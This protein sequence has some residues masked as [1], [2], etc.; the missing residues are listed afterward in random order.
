MVPY[1]TTQIMDTNLSLFIIDDTMS[2]SEDEEKE[3]ALGNPGENCGAGADNLVE[4]MRQHRSAPRKAKVRSPLQTVIKVLDFIEANYC[5]TGHSIHMTT[6]TIGNIKYGKLGYMAQYSEIKK[7]IETIQQAY[8]VSSDKTGM[9]MIGSHIYGRKYLYIFEFQGNGQLHAHGIELGIYSYPWFKVM[10][11]FGPRNLDDKSFQP[12]RNWEGLR[13]YYIKNVR[14]MT[15]K[16]R[17]FPV[18]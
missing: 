3:I 7:A 11:R 15:N 1:N 17:V 6:V 13:K 14:E 2:S 12:V 5:G 18:P 8:K 4:S 16:H 9:E 10:K